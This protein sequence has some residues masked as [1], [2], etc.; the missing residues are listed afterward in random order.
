ML[1]LAMIG[2]NHRTAD[3]AVRERLAFSPEQCKETLQKWSE[4]QTC[5]AVLLAT[6]NRTELYVASEN[7]TI[8]D[9]VAVGQFLCGEKNVAP[10]TVRESLI[11]LHDDEAVSHLFHV[12]GSLDSMVLGE[13]QILSQVKTAYQ[14]ANEIGTAGTVLHGLFQASLKVAKR[15][16]GETEIHQ[17]RTSIPSVA[18]ADFAMQI[19]ERLD[20]KKTLALGA[21]EMA[22][23]TLRYL[24][25]Q[26]AKSILVINRSPDRAEKLAK[27]WHGRADVWENRF[28]RL[29]EV[30]LVVSTTGATEPIVRLDDYLAIESRRQGRPLFVLDLAVPRDFDSAIGAREN[31]FLYSV[32]DLK[33]TCERNQQSRNR[34]LPKAEKIIRQERCKFWRDMRSR[35]TGSIIRRLREDWKSRKEAEL[36]RLF[37]KLPN[38]SEADQREVRYAFDRLIN[39][40]LHPPLESLRDEADQSHHSVTYLLQDAI[41]RLFRLKD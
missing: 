2:C 39:K 12:A 1:K 7:G 34:E 30:D 21:G 11:T 41:S 17:R 15:I 26:G 24:T 29:A 3:I 4:A 9:D 20:D 37:H 32:D 14:M 13:P 16:V 10:E 25:D 40:L 5:E 27:Q 28:A 38:I 35:E 18:V 23:E 36:T 33:E 31:V 6:C 19:F 8:I 22:D